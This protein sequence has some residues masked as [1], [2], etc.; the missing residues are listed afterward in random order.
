MAKVTVSRSD[1]IAA[2]KAVA[3]ATEPGSHIEAFSHARVTV[4]KTETRIEATDSEQYASVAVAN[5]G[6]AE[7][8]AVMI[9]VDTLKK[10]LPAMGASVVTLESGEKSV[11][12]HC[13]ASSAIY[14]VPAVED[15]PSDIAPMS[16]CT[17]LIMQSDALLRHIVLVAGAISTEETRYYLNGICLETNRD[18][19]AVRMIATDGHRLSL[20][21]LHPSVI[22]RHPKC[23]SAIIPRVFV[24]TLESV[25]PAK[26]GTAQPVKVTL[27]TQTGRIVVK[28]GSSVFASRLID[29]TFPQYERV[30]PRGNNAQVAIGRNELASIIK[31]LLAG[32]RKNGRNVP[33]PTVRLAPHSCDAM[34]ISSAQ[35]DATSTATASAAFDGEEMPEI[36]FNARYVHDAL[37]DFIESK[38][39]VWKFSDAH[40]PATLHDPARPSDVFVL[41]PTRL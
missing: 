26:R 39:A 9:P 7:T 12:V 14:A 1:L 37:S 3:H 32:T 35:A 40:S 23:E 17:K 19:G 6:N 31:P 8:G 15:F 16:D 22:H 41:M 24:K 25:L 30:I 34:H 2:L 36:G 18:D 33:T 5:E 11:T 27:S 29:G 10:A 38:A 20:T 13:G 28:I 4:S 21:E